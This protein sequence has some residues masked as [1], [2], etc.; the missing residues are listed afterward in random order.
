MITD[1][2]NGLIALQGSTSSYVIDLVGGAIPCLWHWGHRIDAPGGRRVTPQPMPYRVSADP[3]NPALQLESMP[4]EYA[5]HGTGDF[6]RPSL[7]A[8]DAGGFPVTSLRYRRHR[9][10]EGAPALGDLPAVHAPASHAPAVHA[11]AVHGPANEGTG[12]QRLEIDLEDDLSGLSV[13]LVYTHFPAYDVVVRHAVIANRGAGAPGSNAG[14]GDAEGGGETPEGARTGALVVDRAM[15]A[16]VDLPAGPYELLSLVG[17]WGWE[18][19]VER[20]SLGRGVA[21]LESTRGISSHHTNPAFAIAGAGAGEVH[22]QVLGFALMYSGSWL[23]EVDASTRHHYRVNVGMNPFELRLRLEPGESVITPQVILCAGDSGVGGV[24]DRMHRFIGDCVVPA[25]WSRRPRPVLLNSWEAQYFH[26]DQES[27]VSLAAAGRDL[28]VELFVVDDG[29]F[30]GR[31]D[32]TTS[33]GDW[34]E[35]PQK[36]PDGLAGL[37]ERIPGLGM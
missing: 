1:N 36:L 5:L 15:S 37:A 21:V 34:K 18:R 3:A 26:I 22:G 27:L 28:G 35:N 25:Q 11:P 33:L 20:R 14:S 30:G 23:A 4:L 2:G 19:Q 16:T 7:H 8:V 29:W 6:R 17:E 12:V 9:I 31:D 24:S 13:T 32:D 10:A